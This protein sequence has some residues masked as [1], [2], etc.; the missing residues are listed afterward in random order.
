MLFPKLN[1]IEQIKFE[2][3]IY[4]NSNNNSEIKGVLLSQM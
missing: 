2:L 1:F 4:S 3:L